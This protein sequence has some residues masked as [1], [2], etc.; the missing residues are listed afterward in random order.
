[1]HNYFADADDELTRWLESE[2]PG[3]YEDRGHCVC[4][5]MATMDRES[6]EMTDADLACWPETE[7]AV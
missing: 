4:G 6:P 5:R 2:C 3:C 1:M 7:I